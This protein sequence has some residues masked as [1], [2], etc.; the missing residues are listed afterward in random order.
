MLLKYLEL[1]GLQW[2]GKKFK[3]R[4]LVFAG[5]R[6]LIGDLLIYQIIRN[7]SGG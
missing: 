2:Q 6:H 3:E 5:S 7:Y 4:F 1:R